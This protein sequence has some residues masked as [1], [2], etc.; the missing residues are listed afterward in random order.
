MQRNWIGRSEGAEILFRVEELDIDIPVFTTR[1]DTLFGATFFVLAPEHPLVDRLAEQSP[2]GDEIRAYVRKAGARP[3]AGARR[4]DRQDRSLHRLLRDEPGQRRADSDLGRRLRPD[5]LRH[6]RDHGRARA[7][8]ARPGVRGAVRPARSRSSSTTTG[9]S[10][11]RRSSRACRTKRRRRRS[12]TGSAARARAACGELPPARLGLLAPALLGLPDSDRLLR[13]LR[14]RSRAGGRAAGDPARGRGLQAEGN[15]AA[16]AGRG[17]GSG[18]VSPVRQGR[19]PRGRDD[20]HLRR[21]VVVLPALL[22]SRQRPGAVRPG[23]GGLLDA[24]RPLHRRG[25][26]LDGAPDLCALLPEGAERARPERSPRAVQALLRQRLR[27]AGRREDLEARRRR[28]DTRR[29]GRGVRSRCDTA[30]DPVHRSC[31]PGHGVDADRSR[32]DAAVPA[33]ALARGR[34]GGRRCAGRR[35]ARRWCADA[36]QGASHDRASHGRPR[37][38]AAV[39]HADLPR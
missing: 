36:S 21:F 38:A 3:A 12:S 37:A 9:S 33:P 16:G 25:R 5:G 23:D 8:R 20:G 18:S 32:G 29:A 19:T 15:P 22:R 26:P 2:N 28:R 4:R 39:Q 1:P 13:R 30:V 14:H 35:H 27:H 24:G 11:T 17:L 10:S 34:R 7:R 6:R 31:R